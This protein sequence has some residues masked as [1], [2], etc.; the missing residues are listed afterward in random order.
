MNF[1]FSHD[2]FGYLPNGDQLVYAGT[3]FLK[4]PKDPKVSSAK[5]AFNVHTTTLNPFS[6]KEFV[7]IDSSFLNKLQINRYSFKLMLYV[8]S[9]ILESSI[10]DAC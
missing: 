6:V 7:T 5:E 2:P 9:G 4:G 10:R 1:R 3:Q 8:T